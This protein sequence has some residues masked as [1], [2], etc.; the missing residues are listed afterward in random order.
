MKILLMNIPLRPELPL[1]LFP[2]GL[3]Y[4][5][6]AMKKAGWEF[7]LLDLDILRWDDDKIHE[8]L[9]TNK[10]DVVCIGCMVTGYKYVKH[11]SGV[12]KKSN[13]SCKIIVG[14][15]VATSIPNLL[16]DKTDVDIAVMGE[17]DE[18]I[19]ELLS[20]ISEKQSIHTIRGL[21][22]KD[23]S[24]SVI[25]TGVRPVI[26]DISKLPYLDFEI[27]DVNAYI[28][29]SHHTVR[30]VS[31][32]GKPRALPISTARGCIARCTFCYHVFKDMRYR[33]RSP[34]SIAEELK[35]ITEKYKLNYVHFW[36]ELT[37]FSKKQTDSLAQ[38]I[39]DIGV[40]VKWTAR[41]RANLFDGDE[42]VEIIKKMK[43][44][45]CHKVQYCLEAADEDILKAMNKKITVEQF[46]T[47][48]KLFNKAGVEPITS[49]VLGYPQETPETIKKSMDCCI[50]NGIYPSVGYLLPQPGSPMYKYAID[51]G[52]I[53][54][55]ED[56]IL[57]MGDRQDLVVNMTQMSDEEFTSVVYEELKR[58][59]RELNMGL[60][61]ERLIKTHAC[62]KDK[63]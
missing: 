39:I 34:E 20:A 24:G 46:T 10:Y 23:C 57:H 11:W 4:I 45:G 9:M 56:Y 53:T 58:C 52:Y 8:Y 42:D 36:D 26:K 48:T 1:K 3:G 7:D 43:D 40:D 32:V 13:S 63:K 62:H 49:L 18:V 22:F 28:D 33:W 27:F 41:C 35:I 60:D 6:T 25:N 50:E 37:F 2:I 59:N 44:A 17:G 55:E 47:Q 14:N 16:L 31:F 29:A 38:A 15:S 21:Y 61:E 51:N 30:D 19:V 12:I 5:A 54:D